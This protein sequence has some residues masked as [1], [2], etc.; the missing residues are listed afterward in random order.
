MPMKNPEM[1]TQD[2]RDLELA[3]WALEQSVRCNN[4]VH[5]W[6]L[7]MDGSFAL[8]AQQAGNALRILADKLNGAANQAGE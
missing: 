7:R 4:L 6:E 5:L 3:A 8:Y 1:K 2:E